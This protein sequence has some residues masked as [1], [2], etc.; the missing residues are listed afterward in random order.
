MS[1]SSTCCQSTNTI[2][3]DSYFSQCEI[4]IIVGTWE[5]TAV[6]TFTSHA[7]SVKQDPRQK[8]MGDFQL[9]NCIWSC[10][11][12]IH[13]FFLQFLIGNYFVWIKKNRKIF[14]KSNKFF[15]M[16]LQRRGYVRICQLPLTWYSGGNA[17]CYCKGQSFIPLLLFLYHYSHKLMNF[18]ELWTTIICWKHLQQF[19]PFYSLN[20]SQ[21]VMSCCVY[22][23]M[24]LLFD[25]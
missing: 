25:A 2:S 15:K 12:L 11:I 19:L 23:Y 22:V 14:L 5:L 7:P 3:T 18:V 10:C 16:F 24:V 13:C 4:F 9:L 6:L 8:F 1:N 21:N 20:G 17:K